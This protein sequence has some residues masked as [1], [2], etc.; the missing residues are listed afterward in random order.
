MHIKI[1]GCT[2][3]PSWVTLQE[4]IREATDDNTCTI[5]GIQREDNGV[6]YR[7]LGKYRVITRNGNQV[8]KHIDL[9]VTK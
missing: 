7:D 2:Y 3:T 5:I 1:T 4:M 8:H 9:E 6:H